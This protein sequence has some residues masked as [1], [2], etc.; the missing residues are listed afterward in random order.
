M[1][2]VCMCVRASRMGQLALYPKLTMMSCRCATRRNPH[3]GPCKAN[4]NQMPCSV[5]PLYA[6]ALGLPVCTHWSALPPL[7]MQ[8]GYALRLPPHRRVNRGKVGIAVVADG[9]SSYCVEMVL[10]QYPHT[11]PTY[12]PAH[13]CLRKA[14][15]SHTYLHGP[16]K[17]GQNFSDHVPSLILQHL[18]P[19]LHPA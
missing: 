11:Y 5:V 7:R 14:E 17:T 12:I 19:P 2:G 15:S 8:Q 9:S 1:C 6:F 16:V 3:V 10:Y 18:P 4:V 13:M